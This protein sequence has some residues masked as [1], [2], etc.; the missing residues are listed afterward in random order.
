M[1]GAGGEA[2]AV[3]AALRVLRV[4]CGDRLDRGVGAEFEVV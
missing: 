4:V 2:V 3:G 1:A